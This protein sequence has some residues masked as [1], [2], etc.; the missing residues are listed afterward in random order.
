MNEKQAKTVKRVIKKLNAM[1]TTLTKPERAVLD[2]LIVREPEVKGHT[3]IVSAQKGDVRMG[4]ASKGDALTSLASKGDASKGDAVS[5]DAVI[6]D[7]V[8]G[9]STTG[10]VVELR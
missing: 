8:I 9:V 2:A 4:D 6:A 7:A 5:M 3:M 1:R 10:Y